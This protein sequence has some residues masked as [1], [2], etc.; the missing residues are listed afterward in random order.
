MKTNRNGRQN[1]LSRAKPLPDGR[2]AIPADAAVEWAF[3]HEL[4]KAPP[5]MAGSAPVRTAYG[6]IL[7]YGELGTVIDRD[8]VNRWGCIA[9]LSADALP[10][11]DAVTIGEAVLA[12]AGEAIAMPEDWR[13]APELERFGALGERAIAEALRRMTV[14]GRDG[15]MALRLSV[16][17][18]VVSRA[19]LPV[20]PEQMAMDDIEEDCERHADGRPKWFVKQDVWTVVGANPDGSDR[21]VR[22]TID[23]PGTNKWGDQKPGAFKRSFLDPDPVPS[24]IARAEHEIWHSALTVLAGDL[25]G[26]MEN[27]V[28][29]PPLFSARPWEDA[30]ETAPRI[31]PDLTSERRLAEL[32]EGLMRRRHPRWFARMDRQREKSLAGGS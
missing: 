9:D 12:M 21:T 28:V 20:D 7:D 11:A 30:P 26:R 18:L 3:C 32:R 1:P 31:L 17:D 15:G 2:R 24:I 22:E 4:P 14:T 25:D 6:S 16:S 27:F 23:A 8:S 29:L 13:P 19:I 10:A 5:G